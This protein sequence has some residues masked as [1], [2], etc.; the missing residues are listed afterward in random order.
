MTQFKRQQFLFKMVMRRIKICECC[1]PPHLQKI[2]KVVDGIIKIKQQKKPKTKQKSLACHEEDI[3][4]SLLSYLKVLSSFDS[5]S[6]LD[7]G[8]LDIFTYKSVFKLM[9]FISGDWHNSSSQK[10]SLGMASG[11]TSRASQ[12]LLLCVTFQVSDRR[13][14]GLQMFSSCCLKL[15]SPVGQGMEKGSK[16]ATPFFESNTT[17]LPSA[18]LTHLKPFFVLQHQT[19]FAESMSFCYLS[20]IH[21]TRLG[22]STTS[23][24]KR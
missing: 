22:A 8:P 20:K 14:R 1:S 23:S 17:D 6:H 18:V 5:V 3:L 10:Q 2:F 13:K 24:S 16:N 7:R 19:G 21:R 9:G 15:C 11:S 4:F 12:S